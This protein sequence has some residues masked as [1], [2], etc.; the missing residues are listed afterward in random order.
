MSEQPQCPVCYPPRWD[1][2]PREVSLRPDACPVRDKHELITRMFDW[3]NRMKWHQLEDIN[4]L[5][6][7]IDKIRAGATA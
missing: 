2:P 5:K 3:L 7:R 6:A 4:E 1:E